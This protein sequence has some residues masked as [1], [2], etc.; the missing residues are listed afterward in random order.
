MYFLLISRGCFNR[1]F[2]CPKKK[3]FEGMK[4]EILIIIGKLASSAE[5]RLASLK[6]AVPRGSISVGICQEHVQSYEVHSE[7]QIR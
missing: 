1:V 3:I 7:I 5:P 4:F 2:I 6:S